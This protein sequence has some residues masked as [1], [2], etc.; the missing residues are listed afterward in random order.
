M[1]DQEI[2][3]KDVLMDGIMT[4][5]WNVVSVVFSAGRDRYNAELLSQKSNVMIP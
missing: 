3:G 5:N 4:K 2:L 1:M